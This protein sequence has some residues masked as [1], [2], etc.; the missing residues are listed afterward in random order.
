MPYDP[1]QQFAFSPF[2]AA[3]FS[4]MQPQQAAQHLAGLGIPSPVPGI[5]TG[6]TVAD[7]MP[8]AASNAAPPMMPGA[9]AGMASGAAPMP[10]LGQVL[11]AV[12][13]PQ[14]QAPLMSGGV[15]GAQKAPDAKVS[16]GTQS[17]VAQ[18]LMQLLQA[19]QSP[20]TVPT[21]GQLIGR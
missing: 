6:P 19:R 13:R 3:A 2:D 11:Q 16:A 7:F 15:H 21:L 8:G 4:Q 9:G 14:A 18:L 17:S 20:M 12:Q 5:T 10:G 1:F